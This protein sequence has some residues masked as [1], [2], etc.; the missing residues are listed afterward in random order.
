MSNKND[1]LSKS[2]DKTGQIEANKREIV[3]ALRKEFQVGKIAQKI[4]DTGHQPQKSIEE[5]EQ[6]EEKWVSYSMGTTPE[7]VI[8]DRVLKLAPNG[9]PMHIKSQSEWA[10][11]AKAVNQGIDSYLQGF[12]RSKFDSKTG[13]INIHPEEVN[14]PRLKSWA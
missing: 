6:Q 10:T 5:Q 14:Y 8:K 9:Y 3:S 13:K 11:I 7:Q 2:L 4:D 12:T 1:K